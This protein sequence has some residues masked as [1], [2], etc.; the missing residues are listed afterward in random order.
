MRKAY[1]PTVLFVGSLAFM[2]ANAAHGD[3]PQWRGPHRDA[4]AT[5]FTPPAS[6]PAELTQTWKVTVGEGVASP[7]LVGDK[8][9]VF[10]RQDGNEILRCLNAQTGEE[11]WKD[12]YAAE[13]IRGPAASFDGP[14]CSPTVTEGKVVTLG[15][16]GT[17][18]CL[19]AE[20]GQL[21]WR[22]E[23]NVGNVPRFATSSSP[24]VVERLVITEFGGDESG[25]MVAYDLNSGEE[26]WKWTG[27]GAAYGSPVQTSIDG[28][29]AVVA[30][31]SDKMVLLAAADGK[32][33]WEMPYRQ[34]RYNSATPIV[35][36]DVL[37][38]AGPTSG[39]TA[40]ELKK[41]GDEVVEEEAWKNTDNSVGF[42]TPV[43]SGGML[44]GISALNSLFCI[45]VESGETAWNTPL[46]GASEADQAG[47]GGRQ[48]RGGDGQA[49]GRGDGGG[50]RFRGDDGG[51]Q[52][53]G[54]DGGRRLRRG[55]GEGQA[56][57]GEEGGRRQGRRG[58]RRGGRGGGGYG[59]V[60]DTG[61]ALLALIPN[62]QLTVFSPGGEYAQLAT[63]KVAEG[64]AYAYPVPS[65]FGV[66]VKDQD[67]VSLWTAE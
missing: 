63:Y 38:M 65:K 52:A 49:Q 61:S 18:S 7:S 46:G 43:V 51:E 41:E 15:A 28:T 44:Y 16:Q 50:R 54:E 31:M 42:D 53:D 47:G 45:N 35:S 14:R 58:G 22:N 36:K 8:L 20:N 6:W 13:A 17:L 64:G 62:G 21:I 3:W 1:L 57:G 5:G 39:M 32:V 29:E 19:N 10:A 67:S 23:D 33:L 11:I 4:R 27:S 60:V 12:E 9:Y 2:V 37:I 66:F 40:L 34:G 24:I 56:Q 25:G 55:D 30:P 59:S 26:R 48:G